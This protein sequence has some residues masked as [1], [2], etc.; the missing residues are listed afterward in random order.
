MSDTGKR[1]WRVHIGAHKTGT[2]H[3]QDTLALRLGALAGHGVDYPTR[4]TLRRA[5]LASCVRPAGG[6]LKD[7]GWIRNLRRAWVLSRIRSDR[8]LPTLLVS[9]EQ[10]V[11]LSDGLLGPVLYP[12]AEARLRKLRE[13]TRGEPTVVIL[14]VRN[15][16]DIIPSA[17]SQCLRAG[18]RGLPSIEQIRRQA[19]AAPPSWTDLL[20][21]IRKGFPEAELMVCPFEDYIANPGPYLDLIAG[22]PVGDWPALAAPAS[23]RGLSA[24]SIRRILELD[25]GLSRRDRIARCARIAAEDKGGERFRPFPDDEVAALTRAY[26]DDLSAMEREFPGALRRVPSSS[27]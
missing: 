23:T 5:R 6:K 15:P 26:A 12:E 4:E 16:A 9:E 7:L 22:K 17:Y 13:F 2:T 18:A 27:R 20:R 14:T 10:I 1:N 3:I 24:P 21:R 25:P 11:G 19:L 8:G